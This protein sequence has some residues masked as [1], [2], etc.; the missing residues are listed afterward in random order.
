MD[1]AR[2]II[3]A[4]FSGG[5]T[6]ATTAP[7]WQWD[8]G[9]G[10]CITGIDLPAAFEV[11][12][13][14]NRTGGVS[15]VAVGADGQVTIPNVLLTIG[16][17][18]NAWI[19]LS[20]S[21]GEGETE[22]SILIPVKARPMPETY[23][24]EVSG[25]F[26]DVVRQVS[27]YAETAQTA[28]DNAGA[29]ASAAAASADSAAAS[30]SAAETAK[31]AA[32]TAQGKAEDAQ[33]AAETAAQTATEKAQQTTQDAAQAAQSKADAESA[34]GRAEAAQTGAESAKTDAETAAQGA[35]DSASAA[36]ASATSAGQAA[37]SAAQFA[38]AAAQSAASIE[39]DVQIASQKAAEAQ[40][41]ADQAVAAK[42]AAVTA[43]Q[44]AEAAETNAG[45]SASTATAKAAEAA[46]SASGA[47]QSKT[48]AEAA[49]T[50]AEQAA[51]TL[52]VDNALSDT[53]VNPVQNK[54]V[55]AEFT[56]VKS[57]IDALKITDTESGAI[58]SFPDGA[59]MPVESLTVDLEPIQDLH[60]YDSPWPAGGGKNK[61]S[62]QWPPDVTG[63]YCAWEMPSTNYC[64]LAVYDKGNNS[65]ISGVYFGLSENGTTTPVTWIVTNGTLNESTHNS[66]N[67][68][69]TLGYTERKYVTLFPAKQ[70]VLTKIMNRFNVT[71][72]VDDQSQTWEYTPY[73]NICP[74]SGRDSVTV[75]RTGVNL[76]G[77]E[78]LKDDILAKVTG[79]TADS[80]NKTVSYSASRVASIL[81]I[82][83][84]FKLSTQ[85]TLIF[86]GDNTSATVKSLNLQVNYTDGTRYNNLIFTDGVCVFTSTAG[87]T[88]KSI[89]GVWGTGTTTL[90]YDECGIFEGILTAAEFE[91][92]DGQS[93]T[94]QL[95]QTVYGGTM[96]AITGKAH[97]TYKKYQIT[98]ATSWQSAGAALNQYFRLA[99]MKSGNHDTDDNV[100]CNILPKVAVNDSVTA[101]IRIGASNNSIYIYNIDKIDA[102]VTSGTLVRQWCI[103]HEVEFTYPLATPID[104]TIDPATLSTLKGD[105]NVWSDADSIS[106]EYVADPKLYI[107]KV[108]SG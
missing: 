99:D 87:K 12:F 39:G 32:E 16:K 104:I 75:V 51:A 72:F 11:H 3:T 82:D 44:G 48:D 1:C 6:S 101:S 61:F 41:A 43:Q 107:Q 56:Q 59:A 29:S 73:E 97:L 24:A 78:G 63:T 28:A 65:D 7:L 54:V 94:V 105:N 85:Y 88:I 95:G 5:G 53:S 76:W 68:C 33:A 52:T 71:C 57:A 38:T 31:T 84:I 40:T 27:E 91:P 86:K 93:V 10:M 103:D 25:E 18:L 81:L 67:N 55:T 23:D 20:D 34:A 90:Y 89:Q 36:S 37:A 69:Y 83:S 66:L 102:S 79:A 96:D 60:G 17:N 42:D 30:A 26:D 15:T 9:Q 4:N 50:R 45:Q 47:A 19:Y 21:E 49:A 77:G 58:A 92:Y 46:Q 62:G 14:T 13:S 108:V 2:N 100:M 98:A 35:A 22:Y 8:Y 70:E 64:R 74:I 80:T 106:I